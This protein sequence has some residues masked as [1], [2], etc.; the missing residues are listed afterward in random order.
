M[1]L[2]NVARCADGQDKSRALDWLTALSPILLMMVVNYRLAAV[3]AVLTATAGYLALTVCWQWLGCMP[4]RVAPAL[5]CGVLVACC[6]P[7]SAPLWL[8]AVAGLVGGAVAAIPPLLNDCFKRA[9]V[10]CPVWF[11]AL[12]GYLLVRFAFSSYFTAFAQPV[13]W[14]ATDGVAGATPLAS[15]GDPAGAASL[16][17][18]F[19]GWEAGSMGGGP[20]PAV[21]LGGV[22]LLLRRR[23]H[24]MPVATMAGAVVLLS[25][26]LWD[27]PLYSL[28]AGGTML[29]A[30]LLGD[31]G[32]VH[33]GWKGRL[34]AG[35]TAGIVTVLCR[36]LW[37]IDGSAVGV[38]AAGLLTPILHILYHW[39]WPYLLVLAEKIKNC[40]NKC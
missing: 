39:L 36:V 26:L 13:M 35:V 33:V 34:A 10:S 25:W 4:C 24:L 16:A 18:M 14:M 37:Q 28:L 7:S 32:L 38:L 27:M 22:Y 3:W 5:L 11:P 8:P 40:K 21:L 2:H 19:W 23:L 29:S 17:H 15:L 20:A 30:V 12:A 6:L 1:K 31:E 9:A